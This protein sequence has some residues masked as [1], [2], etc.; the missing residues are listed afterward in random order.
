MLARRS[1]YYVVTSELDLHPLEPSR[2][3][4][5]DGGTFLRF[6]TGS[7]FQVLYFE[8]IG[9]L[10]DVHARTRR[11]FFLFVAGRRKQ[12]EAQ[13]SSQSDWSNTRVC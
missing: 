13:G 12:S 9:D 6:G 4:H 7:D 8:L 1:R 5:G 10:L 3:V 11:E 2:V